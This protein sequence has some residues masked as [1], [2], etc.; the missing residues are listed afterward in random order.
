MRRFGQHTK[1]VATA[2]Q[3]DALVAKF[4]ESAEIQRDNPACGLMIAGKSTTEE[5]V[6]YLV[7]VWASEADWER[8]RTS[9]KI[10]TWAQGMRDPV[11][12]PPETVRFDPAG[13]KGL[14]L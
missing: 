4:L 3:S 7:E 6:V 5:N 14:S 13:G 8:A 11:T 10:A 12:A 9:H 2:G 1:L